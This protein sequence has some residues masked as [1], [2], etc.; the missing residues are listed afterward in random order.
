MM[1]EEPD[2]FAGLAAERDALLDRA[3]AVA[4]QGG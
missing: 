2:Y 4:A 1:A 3:R